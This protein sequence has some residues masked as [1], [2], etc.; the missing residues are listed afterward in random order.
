MSSTNPSHS[1]SI[2]GHSVREPGSGRS[3]SPSDNLAENDPGIA[4]SGKCDIDYVTHVFTWRV[5]RRVLDP[6]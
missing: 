6:Y 2:I 5:M 3:H 4:V 1:S